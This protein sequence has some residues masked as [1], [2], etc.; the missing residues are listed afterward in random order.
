ML[1]DL[2]KVIFAL[3]FIVSG[4]VLL[5]RYS[6]KLK[7][8]LKR[9]KSPYNLKKVDTIFLGTKKSISIIEVEDYV[10]VLGVGEK[11]IRTLLKWKKPKETVQ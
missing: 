10:L 11:D 9:T 2:L 3:L 4:M 5:Y 6:D 8:N 7:F 1:I